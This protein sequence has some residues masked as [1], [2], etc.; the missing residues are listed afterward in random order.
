MRLLYA[1]G[2]ALIVLVAPLRGGLSNA[3]F[4]VTDDEGAYVARVEAPAEGWTAF[5]VELTFPSGGKFPLKFTSGVRITPDRLSF[6]PP[7]PAS[8]GS[9]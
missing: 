9:R 8:G 3:S 1:A 5:F 7:A 4:K 2:S 6:P